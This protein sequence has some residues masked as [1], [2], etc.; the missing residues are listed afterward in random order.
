[1][2]TILKIVG[3]ILISAVIIGIIA[4]FVLYNVHDVISVEGVVIYD[5]PML[6][7]YPGI[8]NVVNSVT[9]LWQ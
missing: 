6:H 9:A 3:G 4:L 5:M 8:E 7:R 1:M 2:E